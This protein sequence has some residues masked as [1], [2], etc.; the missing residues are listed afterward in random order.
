LLSGCERAAVG[1]NRTTGLPNRHIHSRN[2]VRSRACR[3]WVHEAIRLVS[4]PDQPAVD[5]SERS[6]RRRSFLLRW[7]DASLGTRR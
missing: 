6:R 3:S 2:S 4:S 5:A 1:T 7:R